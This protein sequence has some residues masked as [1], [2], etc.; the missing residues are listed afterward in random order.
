M[1][2]TSDLD[3]RLS[4]PPTPS[5][6]DDCRMDW[7]LLAVEAA[8]DSA[9]LQLRRVQLERRVAASEGVADATVG[10]NQF[11]GKASIHFAA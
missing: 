3:Y 11:L 10:L 4:L 2:C 6:A 5:F 9:E 1:S 8:A 7:V